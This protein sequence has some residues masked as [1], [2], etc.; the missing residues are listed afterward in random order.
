MLQNNISKCIFVGKFVSLIVLLHNPPIVSTLDLHQK[1]KIYIFGDIFTL[2]SPYY[3]FS[4]YRLLHV[5]KFKIHL[6]RFQ[7]K[8]TPASQWV[9]T[10]YFIVFL[11]DW[12]IFLSPGI[13]SDL[14]FD[15]IICAIRLSSN[16]SLDF[17]QAGFK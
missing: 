8:C 5:K 11:C 9:S 16:L 12:L 15:I 1:Q 3:I 4:S 2:H 7:T 6:E 17:A 14:V 13:G 10:Y